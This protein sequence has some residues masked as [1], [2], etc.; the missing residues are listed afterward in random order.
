MTLPKC[1]YEKRCGGCS[2]LDIPYE[3]QL[4][5]KKLLAER[6]LSRFGKVQPVLGMENPYHYR[7]KVEAAFGRDRSRH[8]ISGPY[9][10]GSHR[11]VN[12][13][14]CLIEDALCSAIIVTIRRLL[15]EFKLPPYDE[16]TRSGFLRHALVRR[17][18][19]TG[20]VMVVLVTATAVFPGKQNFLKVLRS[21]HPEITTVVQNI[22]NRRTSMVLGEREI[23]LWG[24]GFIEDTLCGK[25]FRIS[26]RS[27]YQ[28]NPSQTEVLYRRAIDAAGLT[29]QETVLDAYC[30]IG[31]IGIIAA[32][33]AK[34][35]IGVE[36]NKNAVRDAIGNARCNGVA[37]IRFVAADATAF[38]REAA[39]DRF[40]LDVLLMDPPRSGSTPEF[41]AA[42]KALAPEKIVYISCNPETQARDLAALT[43]RYR[44]TL[45][46]PVDMFP[47]T[48]HL[49]CIALLVRK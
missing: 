43:D 18:F 37:N 19:S 23:V 3:E 22:N 44:V 20:E 46:Q 47:H 4:R 35:I 24:K 38:L 12:I 9:E 14:S 36:L 5:Q 27:F 13:E 49:E 26:P 21:R 48:A 10:E 34:Q 15:S 1:P 30:G 17:G 29:G 39:T 31:A 41:L 42:A 40:P 33:K 8:I 45:L 11:I 28:V 2:L 25:V 7:N 6:C 16:D 32:E